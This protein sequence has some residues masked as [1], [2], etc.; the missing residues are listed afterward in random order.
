M[1][2]NPAHLLLRFTLPQV[3]AVVAEGFYSK[4]EGAKLENVTGLGEAWTLD[5]DK[6]VNI[7]FKIGGKTYPIHPLDAIIDPVDISASLSSGRCIGSVS[8][9][10]QSLVSI[11]LTS[12][13]FMP[14]PDPTADPDV[15]MILGMAVCE[16]LSFSHY[17]NPLTHRCLSKEHVPVCE[18]WGLRSHGSEPLEDKSISSA[19]VCLKQHG[20]NA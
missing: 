16:C 10:T 15:D 3:P 9:T 8:K 19:T 12:Q 20:R 6:E 7:T 1:T 11:S 4:I 14:I 2:T 18:L 17:R 13:Q 5:C